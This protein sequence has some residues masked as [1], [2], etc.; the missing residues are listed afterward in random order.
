[1]LNFTDYDSH[2]MAIPRLDSVLLIEDDGLVQMLIEDLA[3]ELGARE[4]TVC[5]DPVEALHIA[6]SASLDCAVLDISL[7]GGTSYAVADVLTARGIPFFF[8]TGMSPR[9][10]APRYRGR[11]VLAKPFT[12]SQ[13]RAIL[14]SAL[15]G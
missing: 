15:A 9:D 13:F 8:C 6:R 2:S 1:M 4:V 11:P 14:L 12:E 3:R 10:I 5:R 7:W